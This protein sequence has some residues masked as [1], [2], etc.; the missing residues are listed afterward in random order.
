[1]KELSDREL[2]NL[3]RDLRLQIIALDAQ[4]EPHAAS[5]QRTVKLVRGTFLTVGGFLTATFNLLGIALVLVGGWD[6][7]DAV[8]DD[9]AAMNRRIGLRKAVRALS[10]QLD[11]AETEFLKRQSGSR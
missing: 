4:F 6:W 10:Q 11:E 7:I 1:M 8:V 9:A 3:V 2:A 5:R